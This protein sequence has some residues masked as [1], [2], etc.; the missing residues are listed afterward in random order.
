MAAAGVGRAAVALI[1]AA[2]AHVALAGMLKS[3]SRVGT[4][5]VYP[6]GNVAPLA[7]ATFRPARVGIRWRLRSVPAAIDYLRYVCEPP[8]IE[9]QSAAAHGHV[10]G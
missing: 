5:G 3:L 2:A 4:M 1:A 7:G 6:P 8:S 9:P 10:A